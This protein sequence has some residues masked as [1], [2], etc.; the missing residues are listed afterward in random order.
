[1]IYSLTIEKEDFFFRTNCKLTLYQSYATVSDEFRLKGNA[2]G[3]F[4]RSFCFNDS[5]FIF[6]HI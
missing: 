4:Y 3:N 5:I 2:V 6:N 1:M